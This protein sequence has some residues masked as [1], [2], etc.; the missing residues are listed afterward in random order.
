MTGVFSWS[1]TAS[2]N[3]N[4][5]PSVNW[6]EG[7]APS[8]VNDSA[9]AMMAS[10]AK[11]RDDI[12]G[13]IVT[14]GTSTLYSVS[15]NQGFTSLAAMNGQ[16]VAFTPHVT[17]AA[18]PQI[19]VDG[20]GAVF[21][22]GSS[23]TNLGAGVLLA[24]TPYTAVYNSVN[25]EFTIHGFFGNPYNVPVG[26]GML[27]FGLTAPN[28]SFAFPVGQAISRTTY[29][30]LFGVMGTTYGAGDGSTTFNLPDLTGRVP[31]MRDPGGIRISGLTFNST[32]L[33]GSGGQQAIALSTANL[34][35]YTP[36]GS[37][38][39]V[40]V[41]STAQFTNNTGNVSVSAGGNP[42]PIPGGNST[43]ISNGSGTFSGTAQ[44]GTSTPFSTVQPSVICNYAMRI[45]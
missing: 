22:R 1:Q 18:S 20:L 6:A 5:D 38:P 15:S 34:P 12:S 25:G 28:S 45:I 24:G 42:I 26:A 36:A 44:G 39:S 14:S 17:N 9:R 43:V 13:A 7:M 31:V 32:D 10:T 27:Y 40:S 41:S 3:A 29:I 21:L 37:V 30:T 23:G 35:P 2:N 11:W 4:A 33:G 8:A 19:N 16:I